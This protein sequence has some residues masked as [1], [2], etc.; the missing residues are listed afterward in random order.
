MGFTPSP[1]SRQSGISNL[2]GPF[3]G[4]RKE[5]PGRLYK[6]G[7][8]RK[9]SEEFVTHNSNGMHAP[10]WNY[11]IDKHLSCKLELV[12]K[13]PPSTD[14]RGGCRGIQKEGPPNLYILP[15]CYAKLQLSTEARLGRW[16][17]K[18][19]SREGDSEP[20]WDR[21]PGL[22]TLN[23]LRSFAR[24]TDGRT[25]PAAVSSVL[26]SVLLVNALLQ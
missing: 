18:A 16:R 19:W 1:S 17:C 13:K 21:L 8:T 12:A 15:S 14:S 25:P 10:D 4:Q 23:I 22:E 7:S 20:Q 26:A 5:P 3:S 6:M 2:T 9:I 24:K 11:A